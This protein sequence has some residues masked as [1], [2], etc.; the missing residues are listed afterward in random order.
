MPDRLVQH[1][2]ATSALS[3]RGH[4]RAR[5]DQIFD[6]SERTHDDWLPVFAGYA[7]RIAERT[8]EPGERHFHDV[9]VS[10]AYTITKAE[11]ARAEI[12]DV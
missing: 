8:A 4:R 9:A 1:F 3:A 2:S 7:Y 6:L 10:Q 11:R 5:R 12:M